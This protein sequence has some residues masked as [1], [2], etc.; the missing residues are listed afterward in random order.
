MKNNSILVKIG[1]E[2]MYA[3]H[4]LAC[5]LF[6]V[7]PI[8]KKKIHVSCWTGK[9]GFSCNPKYII[10]ELESQFPG[11][12]KIYWTVNDPEFY[13][14]KFPKYIHLIKYHSVLSLFHQMTSIIW[15]DNCRKDLPY[16]RKHQYYIQTWHGSGPMKKIEADV[17]GTLPFG[18]ECNAKKDSIAIDVI[19][20]GSRLESDI[21]RYSFWYDGEILEYGSPRADIVYNGNEYAKKIFCLRYHFSPDTK[22]VL[23]APT[24]RD[25]K[26][27]KDFNYEIE[28]APVLEA[29]SKRFGGNWI[30]LLRTHKYNVIST[31]HLTSDPNCIDVTSYED[32]Q[33]LLCF[34]DVAI[35]D[36]S[37]WFYD[38]MLTKRPCFLFVPDIDEYNVYR[39]F[40]IDFNSLPF[41]AS[42]SLAGLCNDIV[43]F[44]DLDCLNDYK[45]FLSQIG[46]FNDGNA[47]KHV[48]DWI[49]KHTL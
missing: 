13:K 6:S 9:G 47:S 28:V 32:M 17:A 39:G 11:E 41:P 43:S 37:S 35:D 16:K 38:F 29:L 26:K 7:F 10:N 48:V 31:E 33:E 24:F 14:P 49:R 44:S 12:Y 1:Y 20:S 46:S 25:H 19:I 27:N 5:R 42:H 40:Y 45:R 4:S 22:F 2:I 23:Y 8:D 15:I 30:F 36:Y 21:F 18:Y 34:V 3:M